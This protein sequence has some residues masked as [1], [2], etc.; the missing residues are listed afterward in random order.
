VTARSPNIPGTEGAPPAVGQHTGPARRSRRSRLRALPLLA[1][2]ISRT[3]PWVT[4][5]TGCLAGTLILAVMAHVAGTSRQPLDQGAARLAFLPAI[6]ALAFVLRAPSRPLTQA[7]PVPAW[8][9]PAGH[10]L[11]AI[12]VLAV[13]C[14]AQLR[15]V[16]R[17]IPSHALGHPP[18]V[19]PVLA[20]LTGWCLLA[21]AAAACVDRS[22]YADLGGA[23]AAPAS[24]AAIGLAWYAPVSSR[25]LVEPPATAHG[26]TIAWSAIATAA[27]ALSC[28][29]MRDQWHRYARNRDRRR[30]GRYCIR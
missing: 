11:L 10:I 13:T 30:P 9:T 15:I 24:F 7:T 8:V 27:L 4:L 1:R 18:A 28:A 23:V 26:V 3:M 14:W 19:Y 29:A 16:A 5:I 22:R 2:P 25:F 20:Q 21:V 17:T 12:P 6:A